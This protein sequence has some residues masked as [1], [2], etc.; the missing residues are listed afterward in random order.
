MWTSAIITFLYLA[1]ATNNYMTM[2]MAEEMEVVPP[3]AKLLYVIAWPIYTI[4]E[5]LNFWNEE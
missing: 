5:A 2:L 3:S 1:G 4:I